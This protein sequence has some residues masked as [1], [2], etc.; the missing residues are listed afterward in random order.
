MCEKQAS[1]QTRTSLSSI[2]I[3]PCTLFHALLSISFKEGS[4]EKQG[5]R[6]WAS[7]YLVIVGCRLFVYRYPLNKKRGNG[8]IPLN[9]IDLSNALITRKGDNIISI[10]TH[11]EVGLAESHHS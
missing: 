6:M 1:S 11:R 7:R 5:K 4:A 8:N 3:S 9:V 10:S 2:G